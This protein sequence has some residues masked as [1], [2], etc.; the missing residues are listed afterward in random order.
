MVDEALSRVGWREWVWL[1]G[2]DIGPI[3]AKIDTGAKTSALHAYDIEVQGDRVAFKVHTI[4]GRED[5]H[6]AAV[7]P[8]LGDRLVRDS[9]GKETLRPTVSADL[10]LNGVTHPIEL[11]L[12]DRQDMSFR[13]LIGRAAV[14]GKYL[15]DPG[16]Q[17]AGGVPA[18]VRTWNKP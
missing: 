11:T 12:I 10:T 14:A 2:L 5:F 18:T 16:T 7:A 4:P 17:Y 6:I 15:V 9:G 8:Y 1:P 3:K 13:M